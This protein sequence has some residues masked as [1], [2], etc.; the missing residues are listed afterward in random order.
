METIGL[1]GGRLRRLGEELDEL[2]PAILTSV[3]D[4]VSLLEEL[5]YAL[6]PAVHERRVPSYGVIVEPTASLSAWSEE[7]NV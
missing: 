2:D 7:A 1:A 5:D 3:T 4:R 6:R